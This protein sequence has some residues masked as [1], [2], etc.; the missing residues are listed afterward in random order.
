MG[1]ALKSVH[2]SLQGE[3]GPEGITGPPGSGGPQV[4]CDVI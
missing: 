2:P 4:N 1:V 3:S